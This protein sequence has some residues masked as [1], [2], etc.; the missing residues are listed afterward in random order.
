MGSGSSIISN[1]VKMMYLKNN[2]IEECVT[3]LND[4]EEND[5]GV[6]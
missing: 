5:I 2:D 1:N 3:V 6:R 4:Q